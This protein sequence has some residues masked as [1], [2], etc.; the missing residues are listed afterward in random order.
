MVFSEDEPSPA[1]MSTN[2]KLLPPILEV[3]GLFRE[4]AFFDDIRLIDDGNFNCFLHFSFI[5]D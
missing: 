4:P 5:I 2:S 1:K 3:S